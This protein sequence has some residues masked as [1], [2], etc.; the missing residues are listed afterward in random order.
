[1]KDFSIQVRRLKFDSTTQDLRIL[2]LKLWLH[3]EDLL[4]DFKT[5]T[6]KMEI[7]DIQF[8]LSK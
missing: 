8:S 5:E 3:F 7:S 6:N 2:K 1:M 4:A